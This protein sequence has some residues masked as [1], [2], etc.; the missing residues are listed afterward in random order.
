MG[1][2]IRSLLYGFRMMRRTPMFTSAIILTVAL[3]IA[4]NTT[5]FSVVNAVM[6]RPLPF[7]QPDR[8][9]QVAEK[10]DKLKLP[11]FGASVLN[12]LSWREETRTFE[13]LAAIGFSTF[14]LTGSGEPEQFTGNRI[15]PA[16]THVLGIAPILGRSF[17]L[18]EEKPSA[19]QVAMLGEGI[20]KR[21]FGADPA[22]IGRSITLN[23]LP[24]T[25][26]GVAPAS[27]NLLSGGDIYT[28]LTIDRSKELRLNHVIT[29][30]GRLKPGISL[31]QAQAEMD[32]I[33]AR[34]R[35]EFPEN[36]PPNGGLT[37]SIVPLLEQVVGNVR[38]SL[39]VLLGSVK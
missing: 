21:R 39:W 4:A 23:G 36:Y 20:W 28:P 5:I 33:T 24:T 22:V 25:V 19:P 26:V 15:S 31:H 13:E 2:L 10:N 35:R 17:T 11:S 30:F 27:L 8:V 38:R 34:L 14:T 18:D 12:F 29:V 7:R 32:T 37:F 1:V 3:A 9:I 6:L 16:L